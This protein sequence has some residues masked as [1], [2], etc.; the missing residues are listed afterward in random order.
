[1][2]MDM[3]SLYHICLTPGRGVLLNEGYIG[4]T[5]NPELRFAQH[6]WK[7]KNSNQH[8]KNA[9][10][11]YKDRVQFVVLADNLDL[12]SACL[13]EEMLRPSENIGWNITVGGGIPPNPKGKIRSDAYRKNISKAKLG[14]N[15]PMYGKK[16]IFSNEHRK[17]LS[18]ALK[19]ISRDN[20]KNKKRPTLTCPYCSTQGGVGPINRWHFNN[21]RFKNAG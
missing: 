17:K 10:L 19:G 7:R 21:C 16:V 6:G 9:L 1:M 8:L 14:K 4:V 18:L 11:K 15:N 2:K 12:E 20:L 3:Y 5:K 13:L